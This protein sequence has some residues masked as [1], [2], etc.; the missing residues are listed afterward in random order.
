[1]DFKRIILATY[2]CAAAS[3]TSVQAQQ[4]VTFDTADYGTVGVYDTWEQSPFR[5]GKLSGNCKVIANHLTSS[6]G[7]TQNLTRNILGVQRSRYGS[8]TFG[9]KVDLQTPIATSETTVYVHVLVNKPTTTDVLLVG[10]GRRETEA[11]ADEP[12]TVEQFWVESDYSYNKANQWIDMVFP[13]QTVTG[14]KIYSLVVVPDLKSPHDLTEDFACYIDQICVNSDGNQR[15]GTFNA[16]G[17]FTESEAAGDY[18]VNFQKSAANGRIDDDRYLS[19]VSLSGKSGA[20]S[21]SYTLT[22]DEQKRIYTDLTETVTW[23]VKAGQTFTPAVKYNHDYMHAYAYID[24]DQDG[25]FTPVIKSNGKND[26]GTSEA[27]AYSA[28]KA[29][30]KWY[31]SDGDRLYDVWPVYTHNTLDMPSFTIRS[32]TPAGIYRMRFKVDWN[33]V[34]AGGN[35]SSGNEIV[36]NGGAIV[37]VLLNVHNDNVTVTG[38]WLN[39]S[40]KT[41]DGTSLQGYTTPFNQALPIVVQ[42]AGGFVNDNIVIR[43]GYNMDGKQYVHS[44]RQ[45]QEETHRADEFD[46]DGNYTIAA[47]T[48]DGDV[49]IKGYFV[50]KKYISLYDTEEMPSFS[51][52]TNNVTLHR[53]FAAGVLNTVCLPFDLTA[54]QIERAFGSDAKVYGYDSYDATHNVIHFKSMTSTAANVPFLMETSTANDAFTFEGIEMQYTDA[55]QQTGEGYDF[56]G[57]YAGRIAIPTGAWFINNNL[58]YQSVGKSTLKGYRA[59]FQSHDGSGAKALTLKVDDT[60]TGITTIVPAT[61]AAPVYNLQGQQVDESQKQQGVYVSKGRKVVVK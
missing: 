9:A 8:N 59:Y 49:N 17:T 45:W 58:F 33:S 21:Y 1:M 27:V 50:E 7:D 20:P 15:I 34:D 48:I 5:T 38:E 56:V 41:K 18:P 40:I 43:H 55:P 16:D 52:G 57:N 51:D 32:N 3:A 39:G 25:Q 11:F 10:L 47:E 60:A 42:P 30:S 6:D 12:T 23:D 13:I 35:T 24:Y 28:Y 14:V 36:A 2:I 61:T 46:A 37:D 4:A 19:S 53:S 31:N 22:S 54:E 26:S 44:N 29:D